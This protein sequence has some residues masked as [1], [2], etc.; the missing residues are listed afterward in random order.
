M[1]LEHGEALNMHWVAWHSEHQG[2][3]PKA[4]STAA[5]FVNH[6]RL[7]S[8]LRWGDLFVPEV[9]LHACIFLFER[10]LLLNSGW[11]YLLPIGLSG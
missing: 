4:L 1:L 3:R 11:L 6:N 5:L 10:L 2:I 9:F 8:G 7:G